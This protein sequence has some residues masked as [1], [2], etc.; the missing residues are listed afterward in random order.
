MVTLSPGLKK[1]VRESS[2]PI[3]K[4]LFR[5][6][7]VCH[8]CRK[9]RGSMHQV[10]TI[11]TADPHFGVQCEAALHWE[12]YSCSP[13]ITRLFSLL[14]LILGN[15]SSRCALL[16]SLSNLWLTDWGLRDKHLPWKSP[17]LIIMREEKT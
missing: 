17:V 11:P 12:L 5:K 16:L 10:C 1:T 15:L 6:I 14:C 9:K 3:G 7:D 4:N 2:S 13:I 8:G